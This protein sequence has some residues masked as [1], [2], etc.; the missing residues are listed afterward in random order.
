[1]KLKTH[2]YTS[3]IF[4]SLLFLNPSFPPSPSPPSCSSCS[5]CTHYQTRKQKS[6]HGFRLHK[7]LTIPHEAKK[8]SPVSI[9]E[10]TVIGIYLFLWGWFAFPSAI[11]FFLTVRSFLFLSRPPLRISQADNQYIA[12]GDFSRALHT[13]LRTP[14][15]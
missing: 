4:S 11:D 10:R 14:T 12:L 9:W 7:R 6:P 15:H 5:S 1:M 3:C 13:M 2:K 8:G